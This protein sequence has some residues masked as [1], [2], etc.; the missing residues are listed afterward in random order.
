MDDLHKIYPITY[1]QN[2]IDEHTNE[3]I[4][5][6]LSQFNYI[7]LGYVASA[8][9]ARKAV[10]PQDRKKGLYITYY[11]E[12]D[13][14]TEYFN[15]NKTQCADDETWADD[16]LWL[17]ANHEATIR[18]MLKVDDEDITSVNNILYFADKEYTPLTHSGK[19]RVYLRKNIVN[20]VNVLT[21]DMLNKDNTVYVVQYSYDL[22]NEEL[23]MPAN[24]CLFLY[25]G[26]VTNGTIKGNNGEIIGT[27]VV[28]VRLKG[29]WK[30]YGTV[31]T[32]PANP[33]VGD[34]YFDATINRPIWWTGM[35]WIDANGN[36][37]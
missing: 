13:T 32:R 33:I 34:C 1:F 29:N 37:V 21:Q 12:D 28:N 20:E 27:G 24:S 2:V 23:N 35:I 15:G 16:S 26:E 31:N 19:G 36:K 9:D 7:N 4:Y 11:I 5:Q 25:G 18:A 10:R 6:Y 14:I 22:Q 8:A 3:N 30:H 17:P